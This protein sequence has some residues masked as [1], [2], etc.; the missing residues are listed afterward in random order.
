MA[1]VNANAVVIGLATTESNTAYS[2]LAHSNNAS[3]SF[4]NSLIDVT[5][6]SS[7]AWA[8]KISGERSWN[9]SSDGFVDYATVADEF[10]VVGD[11]AAGTASALALAG[12]KVF[13]QFRIGNQ[14]YKGEGFITS[15]DQSGGTNDAPTYSISLEGTD[16]L[17]FDANVTTS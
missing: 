17:E 13:I 11:G 7:N 2:P 9:L 4:S 14:G 3:L 10:D 6:K 1:L 5:T 16:M 8:E 15:F 12:T